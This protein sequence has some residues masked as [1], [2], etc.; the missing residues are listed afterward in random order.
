MA[1]DEAKQD[2]LSTVLYNLADGIVTGASLLAPFMPETADKIALQL[3]CKLR[4]FDELE[5]T[6]SYP[7]E[8]KVV[9]KPEI[10]FA[11]LDMKDV[12]AHAEE[13]AERQKQG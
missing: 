4:D 13:I 7:S 2:R 11:R 1:K 10:L 9:E 3:N 6:G 5:R 8:N 12:V